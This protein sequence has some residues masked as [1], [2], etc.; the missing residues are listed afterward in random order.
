MV[1]VEGNRTLLDCS[2]RFCAVC[3]D[4]VETALA[5]VC[6]TR[7]HGNMERSQMDIGELARYLSL[8]FVEMS[9]P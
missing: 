4:Y 7:F 9:E 8:Q 6:D 2:S 1:G 3:P 5:S